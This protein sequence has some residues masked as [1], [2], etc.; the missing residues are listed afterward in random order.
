MARCQVKS[1]RRLQRLEQ[2]RRADASGAASIT[3]V[4]GGYR[5]PPETLTAIT[6][7]ANSAKDLIFR[8]P[9]KLYIYETLIERLAQD[10]EDMAAALGPF[11]QEEHAI[12][13]QRH[14]NRHRHGAPT[15]QTRIRDRMVGGT[16]RARRDQRYAVAG[17]AGNTMDAC[18]LD[19][20]G[21][22][23]A[24]PQHCFPRWASA[25]RGIQSRLN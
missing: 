11:I 4:V 22:G 9:A 13:R 3:V 10:R 8:M 24:K 18:G 7:R 25:R 14:L 17:E 5:P 15:D 16:Q 6:H 20:F 12:V 21:E 23:Y 19:G 1:T 2:R